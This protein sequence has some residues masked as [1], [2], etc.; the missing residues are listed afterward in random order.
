MD[1]AL[2]YIGKTVKVKID[3]PLH[4]LH[5]KHG[6]VYELNYGFIPNTVSGDGDFIRTAGLGCR[7]D[8]Y[9]KMVS[10]LAG[11]RSFNDRKK[12]GI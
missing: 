8:I 11:C 4:S 12:D 9:G 5:P 10:G 3:R 7:V 6:F 2:L 1:N